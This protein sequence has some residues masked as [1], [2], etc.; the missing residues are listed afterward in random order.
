MNMHLILARIDQAQSKAGLSDRALSLKAGGSPDLIRNWRRAVASDKVAGA[1]FD[2]LAEVAAALEIS[3]QALTDETPTPAETELARLAAKLPEHL[4][5]RAIGYL[6][7]LLE[8][9]DEAPAKSHEGG[10]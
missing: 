8:L 4:H 2:K 3:V 7:G 9:D 1:N 6:Q 5:Q 10:Q